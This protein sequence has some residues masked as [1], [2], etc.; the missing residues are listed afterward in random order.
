M[1][2]LE[3]KEGWGRGMA[4]FLSPPH[5][6]PLLFFLLAFIFSLFFSLQNRHN[7]FLWLS[8]MEAS[9]KCKS[10]VREEV[11]KSLPCPCLCLPYKH[12]KITAV[13][14][15][16]S[17]LSREP[18]QRLIDLAKNMWIYCI[19][20]S[21]QHACTDLKI[22][23]KT[24]FPLWFPNS[25]FFPFGGVIVVSS[26]LWK[27]WTISLDGAER[28][29]LYADLVIFWWLLPSCTNRESKLTRMLQD[30]LG[31]RTKTSIIATISPALCNLEVGSV[32]T[33]WYLPL[34]INPLDL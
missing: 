29:P 11:Q 17:S 10:F 7:L 24:C 26:S 33:C 2:W 22:M 27:D 19:A 21:I 23:L 8:G 1:K 31:G 9:A 16:T 12:K 15:A 5:P 32:N 34:F 30:S 28:C 14:L 4:D 18:V 25:F 6:C 3:G 20:A 13:L